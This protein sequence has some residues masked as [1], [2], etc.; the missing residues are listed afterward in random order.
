MSRRKRRDRHSVRRAA[1]VWKGREE[2]RGAIDRRGRLRVDI[3]DVRVIDPAGR[4]AAAQWLRE[5]FAPASTHE[6]C[7]QFLF[8]A[9]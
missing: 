8:G 6:A 4:M 5:Q 1:W 9:E 7:W 3:R 2:I